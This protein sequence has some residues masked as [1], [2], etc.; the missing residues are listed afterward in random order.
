MVFNPPDRFSAVCPV[1]WSS[2]S[3]SVGTEAIAWV[4]LKHQE[5]NQNL[6]LAS[7]PFVLCGLPIKKPAAGQLQERRNGQFSLQ[8]NVS[9][10]EK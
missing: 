10:P 1:T 6:G 7:R 2:Q 5:P 3:R 9:R 8:V 4:R